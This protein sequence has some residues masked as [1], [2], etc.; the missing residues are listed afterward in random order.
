M[1][2]S[3][4]DMRHQMQIMF[5]QVCNFGAAVQANRERLADYDAV[6]ATVNDLEIRV[7]NLADS[8]GPRAT[9]GSVALINPKELKVKEFDGSEKDFRDF[10]EDSRAYFEIVKPELSDSSNGLSSSRASWTW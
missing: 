2:A 9:A 10:L 6:R 1:T 4:E 3:V 7:G 5:D 8:A